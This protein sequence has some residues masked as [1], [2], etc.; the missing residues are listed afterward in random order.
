MS[1]AAEKQ[2][3]GWGGVR[4]PVLD[5]D[6][7]PGEAGRHPEHLGLGTLGSGQASNRVNPFQKESSS[8][9]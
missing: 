7:D 3:P 9:F 5:H 6:M 2:A 8:K 4:Q 1:R